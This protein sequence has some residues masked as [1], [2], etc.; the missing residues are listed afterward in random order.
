[1]TGQ[2]PEF[3]KLEKRLEGESMV[4]GEYTVQPV[5]QVTGWYMTA[6]GETGEGAGALLRVTPLEVVVGKG[7]DEP[8]PIPL[9][10]ETEAA[11]KGIGL[12]GLFVAALCWFGIISAKIFRCYKEKKK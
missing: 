4:V 11:L 7:E 10:N 5:A 6:S 12:G 8:Y 2:N 3:K 1:M 9:T